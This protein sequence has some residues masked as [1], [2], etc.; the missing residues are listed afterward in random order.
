MDGG[1]IPFREGL[2]ENKIE[3]G[4]RVCGLCQG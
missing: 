3:V 1:S 2:Y 4:V